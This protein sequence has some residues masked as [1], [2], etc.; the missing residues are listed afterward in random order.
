[1]TLGYYLPAFQQNWVGQT[2]PTQPKAAEVMSQA[3]SVVAQ[4][5]E[6]SF[7]FPQPATATLPVVPNPPVTIS[8]YT[9]KKPGYCVI[10]T[11]ATKQC[12]KEY[13]MPLKSDWSDS[14]E[15]EKRY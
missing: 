11:Q 9:Q 13:P 14:E 15:E 4:Q 10:C 6:A 1:M 3:S 5:T 7:I 8:S 2:F 12:S